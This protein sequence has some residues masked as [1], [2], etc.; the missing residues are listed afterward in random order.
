MSLKIGEAWSLKEEE[1]GSLA[2][3]YYRKDTDTHS[4][5]QHFHAPV[6]PACLEKPEPQ[7]EPSPKS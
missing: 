2:V 1:D 4:T 5:V 6:T 3:Q 7:P